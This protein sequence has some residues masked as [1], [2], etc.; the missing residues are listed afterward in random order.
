MMSDTTTHTV[1]KFEILGL[2]IETGRPSRGKVTR[3]FFLNRTDLYRLL[4]NTVL[5]VIS[6][7][8]RMTE[9]IQ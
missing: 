1:T 5:Q 2:F 3:L 9:R 4:I 6:L 8:R 7:S